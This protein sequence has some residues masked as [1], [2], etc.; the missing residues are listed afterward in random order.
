ANLKGY[1]S[2]MA[3]VQSVFDTL[4]PK[5]LEVVSTK[6]RIYLLRIQL[7]R[8]RGNVIDGAVLNFVDITELRKLHVSITELERVQAALRQS[9]E[10][11]KKLFMEAPLGIAL[12]DSLTGKIYEV[13][14]MFAKIADRTMEE[15]AQ[16]DWMSITHPDDVQ[17]DLDNMA[18]LNAGEINGFQMEKRYLRRDGSA[19][20]INM[21]VASGIVADKAHP[22][23]LCMIEDITERKQVR[24][25]LRESQERYSAVFDQSPIAIE[26]YD[27]NGVLISVNAACLNLFGVV[28]V[29]EIRGFRLFEDPNIPA[30]I[31]AKLSNHESVR[32]EAD[33]D[34]EAVKR[35]KLY[36]TTCSG[37]ITLDWSITPLKNGNLVI[38]Y[39]MQIHDITERIRAEALLEIIRKQYFDIVEGTPDLI[40]EVDT[41]GRLVFVNHASVDIFGLEPAECIGRLAFDFIA[42]EDRQR[43]MMAFSTWLKSDAK[44]FKIENRQIGVDGRE[45]FMSWVVCAKFDAAGKII[46]V[47][48]T[49]RDITER[50]QAEAAL[51]K[52]Q[53]GRETG[54]SD[55]EAG[56]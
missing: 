5:E 43:T 40:T 7:Y 45:H 49:A 53:A 2:I 1:Y 21:T 50:K 10:L 35:M 23:H 6:G 22:R 13:N 18:R 29:N 31:K 26:F 20:W 46:G 39:I 51:R 16:I 47:T 19:V 38:G 37:T 36:R 27:A 9:E 54:G 52:A 32:F 15:M 41:E 4:G 33:F 42:P 48:S 44:R 12:I 14:P 55:L 3:D 30:P 11:F 25:T 8:T 56:K 17:K 24:E 28:D 34:F